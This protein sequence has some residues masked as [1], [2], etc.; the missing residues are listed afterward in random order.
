MKRNKIFIS[1]EKIDIFV[2]CDLT[3]SLEEYQ[4][5]FDKITRK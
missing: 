1:S 4:N 3:N 2:C 5:Y